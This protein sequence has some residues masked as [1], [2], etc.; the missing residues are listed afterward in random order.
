MKKSFFVLSIAALILV[1]TCTYYVKV[2]ES[3]QEDGTTLVKAFEKSGAVLVNS[4]VYFWASL[5]DR[6]MDMEGIGGL[7]EDIMSSVGIRKDQ[8]FTQQQTENDQIHNMEISGSA[9]DGRTMKLAV[10]ISKEETVG[11][12]RSINVSILQDSSSDLLEA[13]QK[14]VK[15]VFEKY[16][17]YPRVNSC[18]TGAYEGELEYQQLNDV[19][20]QVLGEAE[21]KKVEG[22]RETNYVSVSAYSPY[23]ERYVKVHGKKV[24]LNFASRYNAYEN[25]TYIW[26][27]TPVITTEY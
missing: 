24:N 4:E 5:E 16:G 26:L 3:V 7:V 17:I 1:S 12:E 11:T 27:A 15:N 8:G 18:I 21:A 2:N 6:F 10:H 14:N 25:R 9:P 22:V 23:I 13:T 19:A 20:R